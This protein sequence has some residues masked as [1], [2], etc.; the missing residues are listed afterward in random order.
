MLYSLRNKFLYSLSEEY[1]ELV[2]SIL[3]T[4]ANSISIKSVYGNILIKISAETN[5]SLFIGKRVFL[6]TPDSLS[7]VRRYIPDVFDDK[8]FYVTAYNNSALKNNFVGSYIELIEVSADSIDTSVISESLLSDST[9]AILD[10]TLQ[11]YENVFE[12]NGTSVPTT[13]YL[14]VA[15]PDVLSSVKKYTSRSDFYCYYTGDKIYYKTIEAL[16]TF[17]SKVTKT[18]TAGNNRKYHLNGIYLEGMRLPIVDQLSGSLKNIGTRSKITFSAS[19]N[20]TFLI[21]ASSDARWYFDESN[22]V[23]V[24]SFSLQFSTNFGGMEHTYKLVDF[25]SQQDLFVGAFISRLVNSDSNTNPY[26]GYFEKVSATESS[27]LYNTEVGGT[28]VDMSK[29]SIVFTSRALVYYI[30]S[31]KSVFPKYKEW[32]LLRMASFGTD[33][34]NLKGWYKIIP[35]SSG[36]VSDIWVTSD[37]G[38]TI[39]TD[40]NYFMGITS[41]LKLNFYDCIEPLSS[42]PNVEQS[43]ITATALHNSLLIRGIYW[44]MPAYTIFSKEKTYISEVTN[45]MYLNYNGTPQLISYTELLTALGFTKWKII[46]DLYKNTP[47]TQLHDA[48]ICLKYTKGLTMPALMDIGADFSTTSSVS[49]IPLGNALVTSSALKLNQYLVCYPYSSNFSKLERFSTPAIED[50]EGYLGS[51]VF[52]T[53]KVSSGNPFNNSTLKSLTTGSGEVHSISDVGVKFSNNPYT[54]FNDT[55]NKYLFSSF[56]NAVLYK[57]FLIGGPDQFLKIKVPAS[58]DT[59]KLKVA[60]A[61]YSNTDITNAESAISGKQVTEIFTAGYTYV[62]VDLTGKQASEK[63]YNNYTVSKNPDGFLFTV[64]NTFQEGSE[65]YITVSFTVTSEVWK[66]G[67]NKVSLLDGKDSALKVP[68]LKKNS[69]DDVSLGKGSEEAYLLSAPSDNGY[70]SVLGLSTYDSDVD[71]FRKNYLMDFTFSSKD[72][73]GV[74][75]DLDITHFIWGCQYYSEEFSGQIFAWSAPVAINTTKI[76]TKGTLFT[77][78]EDKVDLLYSTDNLTSDDLGV[79][80]TPA[81]LYPNYTSAGEDAND[82]FKV[83]FEEGVA[84]DKEISQEVTSHDKQI[85]LGVTSLNNQGWGYA[86]KLIRSLSTDRQLNVVGL[87]NETFNRI[88]DNITPALWELSNSSTGSEENPSQPSLPGGE[89]D[90][91]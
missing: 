11:K 28:S 47:S 60:F 89:I 77:I 23:G 70:V 90:I 67:D 40:G 55:S 87:S 6:V 16:S 44:D 9:V 20:N 36:K 39:T 64:S 34:N 81:L 75:V 26:A 13:G 46:S 54:R 10:Y 53:T 49:L 58:A 84:S 45:L 18:F 57:P 19:A 22:R 1:I 79:Q 68:A 37:P 14:V 76:N 21:E 50:K 61:V 3:Y 2:D 33:A 29:C 48:T 85:V 24:A 88:K 72:I 42:I 73:W 32:L 27:L 80:C 7:V 82:S 65:Y 25:K 59:F 8:S 66:L 74:G 4:I 17:G 91:E 30:S 15:D 41:K 31:Y 5:T 86:P 38:I 63:A 43:L 35:S 62:D 71:V 51:V 78:S 52:F 12:T 56:S 69:E 83:I